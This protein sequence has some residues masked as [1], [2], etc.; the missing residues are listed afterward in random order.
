MSE[1]RVGICSSI[2]GGGA[3]KIKDNP[4]YNQT[5][6]ILT[7]AQREK[8]A[9]AVNNLDKKL[10]LLGSKAAG[11]NRFSL[12]TE[13]A[14]SG[15]CKLYK[16]RVDGSLDT[17]LSKLDLEEVIMSEYFVLLH[18]S[19][20]G[21]S[22][23]KYS[24]YAEATDID[25]ADTCNKGKMYHTVRDNCKHPIVAFNSRG[26]IKAINK[27][28]EEYVFTDILAKVPRF[29]LS[30]IEFSTMDTGLEASEGLMKGYS[31]LTIISESF[32]EDKIQ[33]IAISLAVFDVNGRILL[34]LISAFG[35]EKCTTVTFPSNNFDE[36]IE[37]K[38]I[39]YNKTLNNI[40]GMLGLDLNK[41]ILKIQPPI[42][43]TRKPEDISESEGI[44]KLGMNK[45]EG[46]NR[47]AWLIDKDNI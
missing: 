36:I 16:T 34:D 22:E 27:Y 8:R 28:G 19:K 13:D 41:E 35:I 11:R 42:I 5:Q 7:R 46:R 2:G 3:R 37:N 39:N 6:T 12:Y 26:S 1:A 40:K 10:S 47:D 24:L 31:T 43:N 32:V 15:I 4:N 30:R 23:N 38:Y 21:S 20:V 17:D 14:E 9:Q 29:S 44:H 33:Q 45:I 25:Y 18:T